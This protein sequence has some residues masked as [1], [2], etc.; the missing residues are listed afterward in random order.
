MFPGDFGFAP[1]FDQ[2]GVKNRL[3]FDNRFDHIL[4][5]N[6]V[7]PLEVVLA[8]QRAG[9]SRDPKCPKYT[10]LSYNYCMVLELFH[11][12]H[13]QFKTFLLSCFHRTKSI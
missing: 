1:C 13:L 9:G 12:L 8:K 7:I 4:Q 10:K 6:D 5:I 3:P 11:L 2:G